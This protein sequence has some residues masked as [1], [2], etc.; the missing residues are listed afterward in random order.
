MRPIDPDEFVDSLDFADRRRYCG[1]WL[2]LLM[3]GNVEGVPDSLLDAAFDALEMWSRVSTDDSEQDIGN[4]MLGVFQVI[5]QRI[6]ERTE[7]ARE[8]ASRIA[9]Y[10]WSPNFDVA[11]AAMR[12]F[13]FLSVCEDYLQLSQFEDVAIPHLRRIANQKREPPTT[14][15]MSL[16]AF[17][18]HVLWQLDSSV[19]SREELN[20]VR[21]ECAQAYFKWAEDSPSSAEDWLRKADT[22]ISP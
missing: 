1:K 17:A 2:K 7:D 4:C 14:A 8:L 5:R 21:L 9:T 6:N 11:V 12:Q 3:K 19:V 22:L 16:S 10:F 15:A 13:E 18:F 20:D